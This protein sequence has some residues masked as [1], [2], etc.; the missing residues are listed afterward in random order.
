MITVLATATD[1]DLVTLENLKETL[2]I[3]D[4]NLDNKIS[5]IITRAGKRVSS[6]IGTPVLGLQKYQAILPSYGSINLQLPR[7]PV[8]D[9]LRVFDG[10][11]TGVDNEYT[12]TDYRVDKERG[13]LNRDEGWGLSRQVEDRTAGPAEIVVPGGEY[14][15]WLVEFTAGYVL[16]GGLSTSSALWSTA[17]GSTST[18][19]TLPDEIEDATIEVAKGM[20]LSRLRD[21]GVTSE[22]VGEVSITYQQPVG[23]GIPPS[24]A[25]IL[26]PFRSMI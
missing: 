16:S 21:P 22:R 1:E 15:R 11:D 17:G 3:T 9:I 7:H 25:A 5:R 8:R 18:G 2:D 13:W 10:T 23:D 12:S 4:A 20:Y 26:A 24:I 14:K 19:P 6:Y